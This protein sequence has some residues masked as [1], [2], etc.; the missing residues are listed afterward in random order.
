[1]KALCRTEHWGQILFCESV[2]IHRTIGILRTENH[3]LSGQIVEVALVR[4]GSEFGW[5]RGLNPEYSAKYS[6]GGSRFG[7]C[8]P[9]ASVPRVVKEPGFRLRLS[10]REPTQWK[11]IDAAGFCGTA[12]ARAQIDRDLAQSAQN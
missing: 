7:I 3:W 1:L 2:K 6:A 5:Q 10:D 9:I 11:Q 8:L 12:L 4:N